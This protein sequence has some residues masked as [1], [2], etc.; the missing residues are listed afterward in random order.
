LQAFTTRRQ[1]TTALELM[2]AAVSWITLHIVSALL[3]RA[4]ELAAQRAALTLGGNR[5]A[6]HFF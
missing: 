2:N 6:W 4:T 3:V 1:T 5:T